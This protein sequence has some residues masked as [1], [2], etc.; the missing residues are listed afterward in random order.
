MEN[1]A[2]GRE[3]RGGEGREEGER[4]SGRKARETEA[5]E[6]LKGG[7]AAPFLRGAALGA[8]LSKAACII[9][10][11]MRRTMQALPRRTLASGGVAVTERV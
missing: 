10:H 9:V 11:G 5:R 6:Y 4:P 7:D 1:V 8:G 2:C 3:G